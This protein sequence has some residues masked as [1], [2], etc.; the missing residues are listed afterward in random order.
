MKPVKIFALVVIICCLA[1]VGCGKPESVIIGKWVG[2]TGSFEFFKDKTGI[3]NPSPGQAGLPTNVPF[4]WSI[5][6]DDE[7]RMLMPIG[8]GRTIFGKLENKKILIVE[9]DRFMKQK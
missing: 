9:D 6:G 3:V 7:V 5:V 8:G 2:K 1:V 4:K